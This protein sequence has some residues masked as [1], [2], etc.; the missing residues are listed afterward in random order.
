MFPQPGFSHLADLKVYVAPVLDIG[1]V[2][3]HRRRIID[4]TG[5]EVLGPR[6]KGKVRPGGADFQMVRSD[7]LI[8]LHAR[9][10]LELDDGSLVYVENTGLR[11]AP[12]EVLERLARGER[13]D[14]SLVYFRTVPRFETAAP[15][16]RWLMS[17]IFIATAMRGADAVELRFLEVT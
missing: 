1:E 9:Y 5:G 15:Q 4:I 2:G 10:T 8:E 3:A 7:G 12:P 17:S 13:V 14:P 11:R 6:L 16:H